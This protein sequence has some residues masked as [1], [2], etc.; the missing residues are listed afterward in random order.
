MRFLIKRKSEF[1][2]WQAVPA[3]VRVSLSLLVTFTHLLATSAPANPG[4]S[5]GDQV[6][7]VYNTRV[8]ESKAIAEHYAMVRK[9][10]KE[11]VVGL[12][13]TKE[14]DIKRNDFRD[15]LQKP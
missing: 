11:Q 14:D 3:G 8:P 2:A 12:S 6:L 1:Q 9:V 10:P 13:L 15:D 5:S 7:L 4:G